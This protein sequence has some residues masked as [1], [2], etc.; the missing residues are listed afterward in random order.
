MV[1][2]RI[3]S[4][5]LWMPTWPGP[6]PSASVLWSIFESRDHKPLLFMPE[7]TNNCV[8]KAEARAFFS[9]RRNAFSALSPTHCDPW[10]LIGL[11]PEATR[12]EDRC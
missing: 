2:Q 3:S 11:P 6:T 1:R 12:D 4:S 7:D 9:R 8:M 5:A 10:S